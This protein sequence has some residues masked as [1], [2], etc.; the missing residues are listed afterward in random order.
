LKAVFSAG[1]ET[2]L[3]AKLFLGGRQTFCVLKLKL[4]LDTNEEADEENEVDKW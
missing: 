1:V 3:Q 2:H 4:F